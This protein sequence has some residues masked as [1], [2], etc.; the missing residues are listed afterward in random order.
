M[1][2]AGF[3]VSSAMVET[4]SN[5]TYAKNTTA[6]AWNTPRGPKVGEIDVVFGVSFGEAGDDDEDND[7]YMENRGNVVE[8][9]RAL[10]AEDCEAADADKDSDSNGIEVLVVLWETVGYDAEI[11]GVAAVAEGGEVGCPGT[12]NGCT[13]YDVLEEDV[14][15]CN[16]GH[17]VPKLHP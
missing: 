6:E 11:I 14:A 9:R 5:P 4:A 13:T 12:S 15:C 17:E 10:Y 16:E 1:S 3:L 8:T 7:N 2:F